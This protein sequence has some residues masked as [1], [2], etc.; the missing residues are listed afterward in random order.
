MGSTSSYDIY[1]KINRL[2]TAI[3]SVKT[4]RALDVSKNNF[5]P[6]NIMCLMRHAASSAENLEILIL[7]SLDSLNDETAP[8]LIEMIRNKPSLKQLNIAGCTKLSS[9]TMNNI[10]ASLIKSNNIKELDFSKC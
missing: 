3:L 5:H 7:A 1:E 8:S 4:L 6:E 9:S 2:L 10:V